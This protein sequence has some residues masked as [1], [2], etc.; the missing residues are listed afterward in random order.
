MMEIIE[1]KHGGWCRIVVTE[2]EIVRLRRQSQDAHTIAWAEKGITHTT[3]RFVFFFE[4]SPGFWFGS[5][6]RKTRRAWRAFQ[7]NFWKEDDNPCDSPPSIRWS[8]PSVPSSTT[9]MDDEEKAGDVS[10]EE[11]DE[12]EEGKRREE[13]DDD[14]VVEGDG[15][16]KAEDANEEERE[17]EAWGE[18]E[19][20]EGGERKLNGDDVLEKRGDGKLPNFW[21]FW[22]P[23]LSFPFD[24]FP[25]RGEMIG[26]T[27]WFEWDAEYSV[28]EGGRSISNICD[29]G[30]M[31]ESECDVSD[32]N[33]EDLVCSW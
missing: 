19:E 5:G 29:V 15:L 11:E 25:P 6:A 10:E 27:E 23:W 31:L 24:S 3:I 13:E 12:E 21:Y 9:L 14:D 20:E 32:G 8:V 4:N 26:L 2:E 22:A 28:A 1:K 16:D 33:V 17:R 30:M 18:V 7:M